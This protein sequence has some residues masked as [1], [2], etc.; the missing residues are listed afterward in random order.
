MPVS[1]AGAVND[2]APYWTPCTANRL[3]EAIGGLRKSAS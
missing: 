2:F 3:F 1:K